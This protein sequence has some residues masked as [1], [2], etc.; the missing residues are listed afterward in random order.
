MFVQIK[1]PAFAGFF[2][3]DFYNK[4][5]TGSQLARLHNQHCTDSLLC[6]RSAKNWVSVNFL[7]NDYSKKEPALETGAGFFVP[8]FY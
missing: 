5:S 8:A 1:E 3:S 4:G 2:I 7:I 6:S